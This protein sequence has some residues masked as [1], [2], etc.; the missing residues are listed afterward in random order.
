MSSV[1]LLLPARNAAGLLPECL[2]AVRAQRRQADEVWIV[3][4]PSD[5]GTLEVAR[6]LA[7][8][9]T[10]IIL[11]QVGDRASGLN[12]ALERT[13]MDV[14]AFVDAQSRL[15]PDYLDKALTVMRESGAAVVGGPMRPHGRTLVG[16]AL[17][18]ALRSPF[19]VGNSQFHFDGSARDADSVYLGVYRRSAIRDVGL[20]NDALLRTEDDDL[21][22]RIRAAGHRIRLDPRIKSTYLCRTTIGE[23]WDQFW[24][25]GVWKVAL[26]T[27]RP[28]ALRP[29]HFVPSLLVAAV[30]T[31]ALAA[32]WGRGWVLTLLT[33]VYASAAWIAA[34]KVPG[35]RP[36]ARLLFPLV[37]LAMHLGYGMGVI[38]GLVGLRALARAARQ[39]DARAR[40]TSDGGAQDA[41]RDRA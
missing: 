28:G 22:A 34:A 11:N 5:D 29:R 39:G 12:L 35:V 19:G 40:G 17:A 24:G 27:V 14:V 33:A 9:R 16:Q 20:Y 26:A 38:R 18:A 4:G 31:A 23:T 32:L 7:D 13:T 37:T 8:E 41:G 1:A 2:A 6:H 36:Q 15:A 21:N 30:G 3:V 25:Y 10:H